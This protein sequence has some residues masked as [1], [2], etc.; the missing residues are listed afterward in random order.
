[1]A[2]LVDAADS[3]S[4]AHKVCRFDSCSGHE[5]SQEIEGLFLYFKLNNYKMCP[6]WYQDSGHE[7]SQE[8]EGLFL[9]FKLN[10]YKMYPDWYR[11]SGHE[12]SQEIEGLLFILQTEQLQD[13]SRL[14][15]EFRAL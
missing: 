14:I 6:D 5:A 11:D 1:M 15:S 13:V 8:T 12:A 4:A 2:E 3:K 9:Y 7:A 10:N